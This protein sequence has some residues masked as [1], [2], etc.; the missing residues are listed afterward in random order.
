NDEAIQAIIRAIQAEGDY[1]EFEGCSEHHLRDQ[2]LEAVLQRLRRRG[3]LHIRQNIVR[4]GRVFN[5]IAR[6]SDF[7]PGLGM[8][9]EAFFL[10]SEFPSLQM[11]AFKQFSGQ[12][13]QWS[14]AMVEPAAAGQAVF[15]FRIPTHLCFAIALVDHLD[16]AT[17]TAI[18]TTNPIDHRVDLLWYEV[19]VVYELKQ[20][21]LHFYEKPANFFDHFKGEV[22]WSPL[23]SV[24]K[25][26][27]APP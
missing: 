1:P 22:A 21:A 27:L 9:G 16:D 11:P 2:Y 26:I 19:P 23:R 24:I 12:C 14:K 4:N 17:R 13:L 7:E 18:K 5:Y 15:N 3:C 8:R 10:F 6:I 20:Q 25:E